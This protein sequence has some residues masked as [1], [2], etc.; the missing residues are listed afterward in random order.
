MSV[1]EIGDGVF[2]VKSTAGDNHLGGDNF[3]K[4][5]VD[6]LVGEFKQGPGHRPHAGPDGPPAPLRGGREG[7]DRAL[8]RA[9][10]ADQ[11]AVH[12]GR[13]VR[14]EAPRHAP[15]PREAQRADRATCSTASSRPVRQAL[16]D[17]KDKGA[18]DDRPRRARRRHDPHAGGPGEG[19][20]AHRQ[21]AAPRRQPG[22]GRRRR[23]RHPGGRAGRRR[24]GRPAARRHPADPGHRDQGRRDDE[25]HRAQHDDPDPQVGDLLD[26]RGQ[27]AVGRDPRPAGRARD[28]DLQQV[29]RQVPAD[30]HPAGAARHP[31]DRGRA[32]TSTPTASSTCRRR[33]SAPARSRRSRSA[34]AAASPTT[35]SSAWSTTP[36]PTPTR[37]SAP[38]E[39][40]EARNSGENAAYQAERQ[41]KD[42]AEQVDAASKEEIEAAIKDV[43]E[44]LTSEDPNE[45]NAK[46]EALQSA[47]H[48]VSEAMYERAQQQ[49]GRV[50]QRRVPRGRRAGAPRRRTSSTPRSWTRGSRSPWSATPRPRRR[51]PRRP[52]AP[53]PG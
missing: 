45:I 47:F 7:Q 41:L 30:G 43:R 48:K 50:R 53:R 24:Q 22:R 26:G 46:T 31:A 3:D 12:H 23:R 4:A 17:A 19:Q 34:P 18:D 9:G 32:S 5:I 28:G 13:P 35:R 6:W 36:R 10:D 1:L 15:D 20:G 2:E 37:T 16:D 42:L 27:P 38:R 14:P 49:Q 33:T 44:S 29:A 25:A 39:L 8:D 21:G 11:P 52:P 40:A 51:R